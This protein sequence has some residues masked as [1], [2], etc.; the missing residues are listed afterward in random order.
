VVELEVVVD[1][2][3][4]IRS[5]TRR[6]TV[7]ARQSRFRRAVSSAPRCIR[8][9]PLLLFRP[10][11]RFLPRPPS[12]RRRRR[13]ILGLMQGPTS[14]WREQAE[15]LRSRGFGV[16]CREEVRRGPSPP[17][18]LDPTSRGSQ[19]PGRMRMRLRITAGW[20]SHLQEGNLLSP[21]CRP[22]L[23]RWRCN[24]LLKTV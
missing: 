13:W 1:A 19:L 3:S 16:A 9:R 10:P 15:A 2:R 20:T 11:P 22:A 6:H 4:S 21:L 8:P 7:G 18:P 17:S 5:R 14:I 24:I 12:S 23:C